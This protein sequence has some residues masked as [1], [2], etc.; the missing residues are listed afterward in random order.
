MELLQK[1]ILKV[2]ERHANWK[3]RAEAADTL[4]KKKMR[5]ARMRMEI[6]EERE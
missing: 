2:T 4:P 5:N 1:W 6:Q 3:R